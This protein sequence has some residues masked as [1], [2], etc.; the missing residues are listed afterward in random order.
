[1]VGTRKGTKSV[2]AISSFSGTK[3]LVQT[4]LHLQKLETSVLKGRMV[5]C[6]PKWSHSSKKLQGSFMEDLPKVLILLISN[7]FFCLVKKK[8]K[9]SFMCCDL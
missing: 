9:D 6:I 1:M 2:V 7:A 8:K 3:A 5:D 4:W